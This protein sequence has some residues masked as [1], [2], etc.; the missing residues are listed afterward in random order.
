MAI[1]LYYSIAI[2]AHGAADSP[3]PSPALAKLQNMHA[4]Q[5]RMLQGILRSGICKHLY[6]DMGSNIGV[7]IRKVYQPDGYPGAKVES[8]FN[9][10]F[11]S[12]ADD[13]KKVC[14]IGFEANVHHTARLL[15][16]QYNYRNAS[17]PCVIFTESAVSN[18]VGIVEFLLDPTAKPEKHEW[19]ATAVPCIERVKEKPCPDASH[20]ASA[21]AVDMNQFLHSVHS[22]WTSTSSY[23]STK[24][25]KI[26]AKMDIE[27]SEFNVL[28]HMI[29]HGSICFI[30]YLIIEFHPLDMQSLSQLD[31]SLGDVINHLIK[32]SESCKLEISGRDDETFGNDNNIPYP[33]VD[34]YQELIKSMEPSSSLRQSIRRILSIK[35][36]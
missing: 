7:Q 13:R 17:F 14:T 6:I 12:N 10:F 32:K 21:L 22:L 8:T 9:R 29:L 3:N 34:K 11:G 36:V 2:D 16:M 23:T 19:G 26:V 24:D 4:D 18:K 27:G 31:R 5:K 35:R 1:C 28:P 20:R 33:S 15:A 25:H 30:D